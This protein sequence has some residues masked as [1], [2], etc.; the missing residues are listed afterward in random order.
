MTHTSVS[1]VSKEAVKSAKILLEDVRLRLALQ[2][3]PNLGPWKKNSVS[4]H[5]AAWAAQ[6]SRALLQ[7]PHAYT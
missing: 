2:L 1:S 4:A 7:P 3:D 5:G 6:A